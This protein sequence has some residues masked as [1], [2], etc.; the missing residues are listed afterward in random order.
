MS[1]SVCCDV[2][3]GGRSERLN[4]ALGVRGWVVLA[5]SSQGPAR[6][7][8]CSP[9]WLQRSLRPWGLFRAVAWFRSGN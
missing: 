1:V 3:S 4:I 8:R 5:L 9:A 6:V 2:W 7:S